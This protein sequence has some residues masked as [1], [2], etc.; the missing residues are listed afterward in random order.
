M[1]KLPNPTN[2]NFN[3]ETPQ[4]NHINLDN[5]LN[6]YRVTKTQSEL[7]SIVFILPIYEKSSEKIPPGCASLILKLLFEQNI[8]NSKT[9]LQ[10]QLENSGADPIY[11]S[12]AEKI[13]IG[14]QSTEDTWKKSLEI[15]LNAI[16]NIN[17]DSKE[18]LR[19]QKLRIGEILQNKGNPMFLA[20]SGLHKNLYE[21]DSTH[22]YTSIGQLNNI[23]K[24]TAVNLNKIALEL[25]KITSNTKI[26]LISKNE[27]KEIVSILNQ[28]KLNTIKPPNSQTIKEKKNSNLLIPTDIPSPQSIIVLGKRL[29]IPTLNER[30]CL[31][32]FNEILGGSFMSRLNVN[33][34]EKNGYSYGFGSSLNWARSTEPTIIAGGSVNTKN[35]KDSIN[36]IKYEIESLFGENKISDQEIKNSIES[37]KLSY[38]KNFETHMSSISLVNKLIFENLEL[39]F[40][41][42]YFSEI[43]KITK[44][45]IY[46]YLHKNF[47]NLNDFSTVI[48]GDKKYLSELTETS[49]ITANT[50]SADGII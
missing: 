49:T 2:D 50:I 13:V 23:K 16:N 1:N 9:S 34:R 28:I 33:L 10:Y 22:S 43:A 39:D 42:L 26:A 19:I 46:N 6:V 27:N 36:E 17:I 18:F 40:H 45:G 12:D 24:L 21:S 15:F 47:S 35:T 44:D 37:V 30:L 38:L 25:I 20:R 5:N 31:E 32:I 41:D 48:V 7:L 3:F 29:S 14:F 4:I 8:Y 11:F